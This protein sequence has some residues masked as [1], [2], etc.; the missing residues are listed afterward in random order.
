MATARS[1]LDST[2]TFAE[3]HVALQNEKVKYK[4][5]NAHQKHI[6]TCNFVSQHHMVFSA[7][8]KFDAAAKK[9]VGLLAIMFDP[10]TNPVLNPP[11]AP[12]EDADGAYVASI[13][14]PSPF[15]TP[16]PA[17]ALR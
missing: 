1:E 7:E 16:G 11:I 2:R 3:N 9:P 15:K 14:W 5:S 12:A 8:A 17:G 13:E 6:A 10:A 4:M